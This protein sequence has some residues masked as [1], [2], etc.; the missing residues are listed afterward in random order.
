MWFMDTPKLRNQI[1]P[2]NFKN[3]NLVYEI[4]KA[5]KNSNFIQNLVE[6]FEVIYYLEKISKII[7]TVI[8]K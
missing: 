6:H 2:K 3:Q 8:Q 1:N 5:K 4:K 7:E